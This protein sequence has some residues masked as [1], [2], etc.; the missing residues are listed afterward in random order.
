MTY[1]GR[2]DFPPPASLHVVNFVLPAASVSLSVALA[3]SRSPSLRLRLPPKLSLSLT[4]R[5]PL[6]QHV[7]TRLLET[8]SFQ[9]PL[10]LSLFH[11]LVHLP[12]VIRT[13]FE[14]RLL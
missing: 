10:P 1:A 13:A 11:T 14:T 6:Q 5:V 8:F 7:R 4:C 3:V 12:L 2:M 9:G